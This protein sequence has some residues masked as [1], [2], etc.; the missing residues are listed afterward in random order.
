MPRLGW[1]PGLF[2]T[3]LMAVSHP[4]LCARLSWGQE[5]GVPRLQSVHL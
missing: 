4:S 2:G 5:L 3:Q 1:N